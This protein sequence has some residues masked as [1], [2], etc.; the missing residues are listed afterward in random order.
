MIAHHENREK[1]MKNTAAT[2]AIIAAATSIASA[3][4][5]NMKFVGTGAGRSV[6]LNFNDE[7]MNVFA[8]EL[9]HQVQ[10]AE[11]PNSFLN[12]NL[13]TYCADITEHVISD[14]ADYQVT[15]VDYVPVSDGVPAMNN[16]KSSAIRALYATTM[17]SHINR[18]FNKSQ[19]AA[20]QIT[21]WEI[22]NDYNGNESSIDV[23]AGA[24]T[25]SK[26]NGKALQNSI[27]SAV[28]EFKQLM[29]SGLNSGYGN[30]DGVIG[31]ANDGAQ[32][33]LAI[34]APGAFALLATGGLLTT[35][36]RRNK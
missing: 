4:I 2:I 35:R 14:F 23:S 15:S 1:H 25:F 13:F 24:L 12:G 10:G 19:A 3:D 5:V 21:V 36:R 26:T 32:D 6:K 33:Q 28:E 29:S 17:D 31:L 16:T 11:S 7:S 8:G 34:P 30:F 27:A 18:S 20:F 9:E 22:V